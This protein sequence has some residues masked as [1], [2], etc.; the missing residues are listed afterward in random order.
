MQDTP[1]TAQARKFT[2]HRAALFIQASRISFAL[3]LPAS[4]AFI[5]VLKCCSSPCR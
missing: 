5:I 3:S 4:F 2:S 1:L